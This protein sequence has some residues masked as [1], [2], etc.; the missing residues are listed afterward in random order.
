MLNLYETLKAHPEYFKQLSCKEL[1]FAQYDCPQTDAKQGLYS[2]MNYI[3]YV[4][5]GK[6]TLYQPGRSWEMTEGKCIFS[7]KGGWLAGKGPK[8]GWCVMVFFIPDNYLKQFVKEYRPHLPIRKTGMEE[9]GQMIELN[10]NETT[11]SFFYAMVPYFT[12]N[13]PPPED[14]LDLKFRELLFNILINPENKEL[15]SC[16]CSIADCDKTPLQYIMEANF[17]YNLPLAEFARISHRSLPTFKR[18]FKEI[19]KTTPGKWLLQKRLDHACLLLHTSAKTVNDIAFES[20]F[21]NSTHFS[22][23]FKQKFGDPPQ[24]FRKKMPALT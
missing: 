16:I 21:E 18:E 6:R 1:L 15:V 9:T 4:L 22:R 11:R 8:D 5:S 12:Q 3:A 7:K 10:V 13:P 20:G 14:L 24:H 19:F 2:E 17:T 23:V